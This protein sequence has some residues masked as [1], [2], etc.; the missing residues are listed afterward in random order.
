MAEL[1]R[2]KWTPAAYKIAEHLEALEKIA[3][4]LG[5]DM[6]SIAVSSGE[7]DSSWA[8][9]QNETKTFEVTMCKGEVTLREGNDR[10]IKYTKT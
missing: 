10:Y 2:E 9:Y 1:T 6:L 5:I 4:E 3:K 8:T 7:K